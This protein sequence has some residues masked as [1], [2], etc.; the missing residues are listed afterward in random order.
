MSLDPGNFSRKVTKT[1][2]FLEAVGDKRATGNGRPAALY[3]R[4]P[5]RRMHPPMFRGSVAGSSRVS[6]ER[7]VSPSINVMLTKSLPAA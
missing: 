6:A 5:A 1:E 2:G 4:G 7:T 3:R